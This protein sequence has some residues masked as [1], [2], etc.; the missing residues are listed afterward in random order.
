MHVAGVEI[1]RNKPENVS[2]YVNDELDYVIPVYDDA[3]ETCPFFQEKVN[4]RL[5]FGFDD[6]AFFRFTE[7]Q[8]SNEFRSIRNII[9][10]TVHKF[11]KENLI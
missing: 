3:I 5:H 9:N 10:T 11:Y 1:S 4:H 8:I 2:K 6:P 7:E